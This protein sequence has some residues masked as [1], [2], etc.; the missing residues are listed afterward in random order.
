MLD[1]L[2]LNDPEIVISVIKSVLITASVLK[3]VDLIQFSSSIQS[4]DFL[5]HSSEHAF[6]NAEQKGLQ[7]GNSDL[8]CLVNWYTVCLQMTDKLYQVCSCL[9]AMKSCTWIKV[10]T[11][12]VFRGVLGDP[13]NCI[14]KHRI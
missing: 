8:T 11:L 12:E 3:S 9:A 1:Y 6:G 14:R 13:E 10:E 5:S 2:L 4:M 7:V